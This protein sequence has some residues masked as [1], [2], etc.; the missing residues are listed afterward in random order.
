MDSGPQ[1]NPTT[2]SKPKATT[3]VQDAEK[4]LEKGLASGTAGEGASRAPS[5]SVS[6]AVTGEQQQQQQQQEEEE[7]GKPQEDDRNL[8]GWDGDDDPENPLN[9]TSKKKWT[10]LALLSLVTLIT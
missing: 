5:T 10:N 3:F 9:W 8:V 4:D 6:E 1:P 2:E 7:Q